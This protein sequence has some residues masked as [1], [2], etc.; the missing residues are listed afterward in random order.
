MST[1]VL[2]DS[3]IDDAKTLLIIVIP[4]IVKKK[5]AERWKL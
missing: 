4:A 1:N 3:N 5:K 2:D